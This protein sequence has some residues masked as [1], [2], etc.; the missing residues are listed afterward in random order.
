M[1]MRTDALVC[2][3]ATLGAFMMA[4]ALAAPAQGDTTNGIVKLPTEKIASSG[5]VVAP[6][7]AAQY[8]SQVEGIATVI[9]PQPLLT[10]SSKLVAAHA[11]ATAA[12]QQASAAESEAKRANGLYSHGGNAALRDVQS[13]ASAAAAARAQQVAA[14][15]AYDAELAGARADWG[16]SLPA[17][18]GRGPQALADYANGRASLLVVAMPVGSTNLAPANIHV[19]MPSGADLTA[20]L[21][22][23]SPR[24]DAVLQGPTFFYRCTDCNLRSGWRLSASV[25]VNAAALN[26]VTVPAT[27][28]IWYAGQP[29]VYVQTAPDSFQRRSVAVNSR[30][31]AAGWF[32]AKGFRAGERIVVRGGELLL[33]Q[34]L[35]PP[36][37]AKPPSGD[38]DDG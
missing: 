34:E 6:L 2:N 14:V 38:D 3:L 15:S 7:A 1:L 18:A 22:G 24:A 30:D 28:V 5:I 11:T 10:L 33:S 19:Q 12:T 31:S 8:T 20:K 29:W 32:Q 26:G 23:A 16:A 27:A 4:M 37:G 25:P 21:L 36:P 9:D 35:L 13:A 17:L